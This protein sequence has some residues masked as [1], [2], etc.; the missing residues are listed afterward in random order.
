VKSSVPAVEYQRS[1]LKSNKPE[2]YCAAY[3]E[4]HSS[5]ATVSLYFKMQRS[6]RIEDGNEN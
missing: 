5:F 3:V 4:I 1:T 2:P 6:E